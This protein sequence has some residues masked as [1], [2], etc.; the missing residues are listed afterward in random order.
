RSG[1]PD[2]VPVAARLLGKTRR[3][4]PEIEGRVRAMIRRESP[5][6]LF[7]AV[8]SAES[9]KMPADVFQS[10]LGKLLD[11]F[12]QDSIEILQLIGRQGHDCQFLAPKICDH[13]TNAIREMD[14]KTVD[15]GLECLRR[16]ES[17]PDK[18]LQKHIKSP[19]IQ[20]EA[21][22]RLAMLK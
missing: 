19:E 22:E 7:A 13:V 12:S 14:Q 20:R 15:E 3:P 17:S 10:K 18:A 11:L 9:L 1:D 6:T 5:Q 2:L 4:T 21:L 8:L 16:I